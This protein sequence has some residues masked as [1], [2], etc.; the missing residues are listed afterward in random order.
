MR[1]ALKPAKPKNIGMKKLEI[2]PR[3]RSSICLV[4]IGDSPTR[5]PATK[6]PSTVW[7]PI[8]CVISAITLISSRITVMT[9]AVLTRLSLAQRMS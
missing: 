9:G 7:T 2:N 1:S 5:M 8:R 4:R 6:A 3:R